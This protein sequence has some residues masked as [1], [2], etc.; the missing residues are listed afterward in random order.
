MLIRKIIIAAILPVILL[1]SNCSFSPNEIKL[2][3]EVLESSPDSALTILKSIK[4]YSTLSESDQALYGLIYFQ[5][6]DESNKKFESDTLLTK[7]INYY[8]SKND[9]PQLSRCLYFK[10]RMLKQ[11]Q[12]FDDASILLIRILNQTPSKNEN[13]KLLAKVYSDLAD[14]CSSQQDYQE[15]LAKYQQSIKFFNKSGD[16]LGAS[17]QLIYTGRVYRFTKQHSTANKFYVQALKQQKDSCLHGVAYQEI[18]I[19]YYKNKKFDSAIKYLNISLK[20]PYKGKDY[21]IRS[22]CLAELY[23]DLNKNDSAAK[24]A[25]ISLNY[26]SSFFIQRDCYRILA[27]TAY[28]LGNYKELE[29]FLSKYQDCSDSV[30]KIEGQT[31]SSVIEN[32]FQTKDSVTSTRKFL[33]F[34]ILIIPIIISIS[35]YFVYVLRKK[36]KGK[37]KEL[38]VVGKKL[39]TKQELLKKNIVEKINET[40]AIQAGSYKSAT[41]HERELLDKKLYNTCLHTDDWDKFSTLMNQLFNNIIEHIEQHHPDI[42]RKELTWCCLSLLKLPTPDIALILGIQQ[43]SLYKLKQRLAQKINIKSM[44]EFDHWLE[45]LSEER[46]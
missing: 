8:Q 46:S 38:E 26:P 4:S 23:F 29:K 5:A 43:S 31:K 44:K 1:L 24:Y 10:A 42:N 30:R 17:Y 9:I 28:A 36:N 41:V 35:I 45:Q 37:D 3:E 22:L 16:S 33:W 39:N 11:N 20:F 25:A 32:L 19:N 12:R 40:R 2:A 27:N 6:L 13:L 14:I 15:A 34:F 7:S 21:S 18:G